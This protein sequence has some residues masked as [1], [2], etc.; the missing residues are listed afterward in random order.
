MPNSLQLNKYFTKLHVELDAIILSKKSYFRQKKI[1]NKNQINL[2]FF[3]FTKIP[4]YLIFNK[5]GILLTFANIFFDFHFFWLQ[6]FIFVDFEH[7]F[8]FFLVSISI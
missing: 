1:Q 5:I 6:N 2:H 3:D 8:S 4:K 7:I